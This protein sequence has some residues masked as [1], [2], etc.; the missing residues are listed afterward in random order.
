MQL[1]GQ[2]PH[3]LALVCL[4]VI[5]SLPGSR[6]LGCSGGLLQI[7]LED[8]SDIAH[9]LQAHKIKSERDIYVAQN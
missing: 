9:V 4:G 6:L 7:G 5:L 3:L 2:N 1:G 8:D